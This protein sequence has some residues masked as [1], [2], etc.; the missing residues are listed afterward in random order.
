[1]CKWVI[2][3]IGAHFILPSPTAYGFIEYED[4]RDAEVNLCC[5]LLYSNQLYTVCVQFVP[6]LIDLFSQLP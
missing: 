5:W 2:I 6:N 4:T 3:L 1:M